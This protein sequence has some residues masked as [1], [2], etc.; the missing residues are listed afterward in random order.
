M[1]NFFFTLISWSHLSLIRDIN[2]RRLRLRSQI[3]FHYNSC[4]LVSRPLRKHLF[5]GAR[6]KAM[7][8]EAKV[9][10]GGRISLDLPG[11]K[12]NN[13]SPHACF[14]K[15]AVNSSKQQW[16]RRISVCCIDPKEGEGEEWVKEGVMKEREGARNGRICPA[17]PL[18]RGRSVAIPRPN[19]CSEP[20]PFSEREEG[21]K[22]NYAPSSWLTPCSLRT[23]KL[24]LSKQI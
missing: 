5:L 19:M 12:S 10:R 6:E 9:G 3:N 8:A 23:I 11:K 1:K 14:A 17:G 16:T 20:Q 22:E 21:W 24:P 4:C 15:A 2:G 7:S 18:V 13:I